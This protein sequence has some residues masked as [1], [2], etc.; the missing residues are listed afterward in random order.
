MV[1]QGLAPSRAS[2]Q[3]LIESHS[4]LVNGSIAFKASRAVLPADQ[5]T[6][7]KPS[8]FVGRGG[9]KLFGFFDQVGLSPAG[10]VCLDVGSSTGGFVDCMLQLGALQVTA[11]DIGT[12]QLDDRLRHDPRV[13][14]LEKTDVRGFDPSS[15]GLSGF[16][17]V[18]CDL[19]FISVRLVASDLYRLAA[20][21]RGQLVCLV[22]PQYEVGHKDASAARGVIKDPELW[23]ASVREAADE[24]VRCG[25]QV[26]DVLPSRLR[27]TSGNQEFFIHASSSEDINWS[28][29]IPELVDLAVASATK[30]PQLRNIG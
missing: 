4:V 18:T 28:Q 29:E 2:A 11:I 8:R 12:A 27:G 19:S 16:D 15:Y 20:L 10:M 13:L 6:L 17:L 14:S 26:L 25:F 21:R 9:E 30:V 24:L 22:K 1:D 23:K 3:S 5:L 7:V